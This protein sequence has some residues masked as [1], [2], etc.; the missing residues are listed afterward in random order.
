MMRSTKRRSTG[1]RWAGS[2][3]AAAVFVAVALVLSG[4]GGGSSS[5][6]D[7]G[8][9]MD[10]SG[11]MPSADASATAATYNDADV[12]FAQSMVPHHQQ[13][14]QMAAL[15]DQRASSAEVRNLATKI[16]AAQQPEI[17]TMNGWLRAWGKPA[18]MP[19]MSSATGMPGMDHGAMPGMMSD[20]D[21]G[22]LA[23]AKGKDFDRQFLTLMISHHEGA[24]TMA[25]DEATNGVNSDA[26]ALAQKIITDQQTEI[27]TMRSML[28]RL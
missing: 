13:A 19:G 21:M 23:A 27:G 2:C 14:V 12:T 3:G 7:G 1:A 28:G 8:S 4:C 10:H 18:A 20:A 5:G 9:G 24:I 6:S 17:D 15:A 22:K 11:T 25:K 26:K 16:K